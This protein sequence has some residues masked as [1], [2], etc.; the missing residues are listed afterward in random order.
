MEG[1]KKRSSALDR[2]VQFYPPPKYSELTRAYSKVNE[3]KDSE[4]AKIALKEF[5]DRMPEAERRR[6]LTQSKHSY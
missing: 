6:I 1:N 2:R 5:F 4:V 3:M